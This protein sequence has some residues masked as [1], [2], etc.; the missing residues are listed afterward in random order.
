MGADLAGRYLPGSSPLHRL[1]ARAKLLC[2]LLLT[3]AVILAGTAAGYALVIA[4]VFA[5][6]L[7]SG[8][9]GR[10]V[11][12]T[13]LRLKYFY[14]IVFLMNALFF[15]TEAPLWHWGIFSLS[16]EGMARGLNVI[17]RI[18]PVMV[19][20]AL[21][22]QT[23]KPLEITE[24]LRFLVR[25]L[26]VLRLPADEVAMILSVA[27]QFIPILLEEAEAIKKAQIARGARFES[28]KLHERAAALLPLATPI[29]L[30]AFQRADEL[31]QAMEARGYRGARY[32]TR[33]R[34]TP[35][36]P[37]AKGAVAACAA[38]CAVM[39]WL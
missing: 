5:L 38:L 16:W 29:F 34:T 22:T 27:V 25:P 7:A 11:F 20:G 13:V 9:P 2:F 8:L 1:D 10:A 26:R 17:L 15:T 12:G 28:K 33:R 30:A 14:L 23:T 6:F 4:A 18:W 24:A 32:R 37:A 3:A 31:S 39:V 19:L 36:P 21:L 35:L